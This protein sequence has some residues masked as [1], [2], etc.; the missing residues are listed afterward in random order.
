M[1]TLLLYKNSTYKSYF[2]SDPKRLPQLKELFNSH[3]IKRFRRTHETHYWTLDFIEAVLKSRK[4]S[5]KR[6]S[7]GQK[8]DYNRFDLIITV[9]GDGTFLEASRHIK[10]QMIV[11]VN[12]D[13]NWSVGRF[14]VGNAKNFE[15]LLDLILVGQ[16]KTK[17]FQRIN[18]SFNDKQRE[19]TV[20]N[21]C[22]F[23]HSNPAAMSRYHLSLGRIKEEQRSSGMW[24]ATAAGS[25][26]AIHSAGGHVMPPAVKNLQYHPRELYK[27]LKTDYKLKGGII[28]PGQTFAITSLMREGIVYIDGCHVS[29]PFSFGQ[30]AFLTLSK[31]P[32]KTFEAP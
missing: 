15:K 14:C 25:T 12:S 5:Y 11:G 21:D 6:A 32:L 27:G 19:W 16:A 7:R 26:G 9:G 29:T 13:P 20:L 28:K 8:V 2:L 31:H 17:Y 30:I 3:E 24:V 23:C 22:L 1:R 4:V 18:L 10:K